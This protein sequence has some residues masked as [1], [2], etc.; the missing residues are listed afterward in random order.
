MI[1]VLMLALDILG[2]EYVTKNHPVAFVG[3][4]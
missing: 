4:L 2:N 1:D 3:A